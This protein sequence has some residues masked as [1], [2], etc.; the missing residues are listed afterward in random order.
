MAKKKEK[1]FEEKLDDTC[2]CGCNHEKCNCGEEC[3]C[4]HENSCECENH[5]EHDC[6][7][8]CDECSCE[9]E[10]NCN[11]EHEHEKEC[12]EDEFKETLQRLQAEFDNYRK[13]T[14]ASFEKVKEDGIIHS[15]NKLLPVLDS[16]KSAKTFVKD[17][18]FLKSLELI[19]KQFNDGLAALNITKIEA[20]NEMFNPNLHNAVLTGSDAE[21]PEDMILEVYQD[22]YKLG[23][24]V[25]RHSVVKINK[26]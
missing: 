2:N 8:S 14:E 18:E 10:C 22:G 12:R 5:E 23:E 19:E 1:E 15:I 16:F 11:C 17:E 4:N 21:K 9:E 26:C 7:C 6:S 24:R 3:G 20:E 25:I 13:R